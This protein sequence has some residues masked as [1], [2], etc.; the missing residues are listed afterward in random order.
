[1]LRIPWAPLNG[2][3]F[4]IVF[5]TIMLLCLVGVGNL[6]PFT[7]IP[8]VFLVFGIWL[9]V[10]ALALPGPDD[11]YAPPRSMILA[12]GGMVAFLG[13]IPPQA[14]IID[15]RSEEHTSELQSRSDLVCRLLLE[16]KKKR[17]QRKTHPLLSIMLC[18]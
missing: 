15:L 9:I 10:A 11:R 13:A 6:N 12:W 16:K 18:R 2:G 8:L 17:T 3:I 14:R 5:G 1:M 4:L 7:G